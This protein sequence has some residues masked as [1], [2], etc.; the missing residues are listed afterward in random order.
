MIPR[1][2]PGAVIGATNRQAVQDC[3]VRFPGIKQTEIAER[4]GLSVSA[5]GRHVETIRRTWGAHG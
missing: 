4:L 3:L 5:V 2:S 1:P